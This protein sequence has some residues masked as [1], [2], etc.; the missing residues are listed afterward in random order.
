MLLHAAKELEG[1]QELYIAG[2]FEEVVFKIATN[3]TSKAEQLKSDQEEADTR[4]IFHAAFASSCGLETIVVRS[5]DTDVLVL[6]I[7]HRP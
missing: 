3:E 1:T 2:G 7:H 5:P 4:M 6:L